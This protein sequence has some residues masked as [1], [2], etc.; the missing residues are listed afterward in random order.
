MIQPI[1]LYNPASS[2]LKEPTLKVDIENEKDETIVLVQDLMDTLEWVGGLGL[3]ANQIAIKKRVCVV[4]IGEDIIP[5]VNPEII[6][7]EGEEDSTEAC[8]SFPDIVLSV[9]R[10]K[11][12]TVR[13]IDPDGFAEREIVVEFPNS[14][15]IQHEIDH[16]DGKTIIDNLTP[17]Q[18]NLFATKLK[19]VARGTVPI[20]YVGLIWKPN[21]KSWALVGSRNKI[22]EMNIY[23]MK[24]MKQL[25]ESLN[26]TGE[27]DGSTV[28]VDQ[29]NEEG[30]QTKENPSGKSINTK[31]SRTP[32]NG[33]KKRY[34]GQGK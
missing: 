25:A 34:R 19:R 22:L 6:S 5:M 33:K 32:K 13:Y 28:E 23:R 2:I 16:L 10:Y 29:E 27:V 17:M 30:I 12:I 3:A 21:T 24:L 15:V 14:V 18:R 4:K 8:L 11:D 26:Q 31:L 7:H 9:K 20:D 1:V